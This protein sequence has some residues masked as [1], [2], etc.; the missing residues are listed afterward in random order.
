M[1]SLFDHHLEGTRFILPA[2]SLNFAVLSLGQELQCLEKQHNHCFRLHKQKSISL[3]AFD[4]FTLLYLL[5]LN[6]LVKFPCTQTMFSMLVFMSRDPGDTMSKV[7]CCVEPSQCFKNSDFD[8][9]I[10]FAPNTPIKNKFD[11]KTKIQ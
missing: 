4:I 9:N 6:F 3:T 10:V 1:D 2:T 7:S 5:Y 8:A 11:P